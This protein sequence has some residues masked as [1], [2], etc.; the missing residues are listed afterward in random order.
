MLNM[1]KKINKIVTITILLNIPIFLCAEY[2]VNDDHLLV[3]NTVK[4][5]EEIGSEAKQKLNINFYVYVVKKMEIDKNLYSLFESKK[6]T[7]P[8]IVIISSIEDKKIDIINSQGLEKLFDKESVIEDY[9]V[10]LLINYGKKTGSPSAAMLNGYS[11]LVEN[12][13]EVKNITL[14]N[15]IGSQSKTVVDVVRFLVYSSLL[16]FFGLFI[17]TRIKNKK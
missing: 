7:K 16:F 1:L 6:F 2:V 11:Q 9:I 13:A 4:L 3:D 15:T 14:S 17:Y 5:I 12:V 8:Y 10:P